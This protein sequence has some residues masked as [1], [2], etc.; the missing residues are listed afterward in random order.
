MANI[1][2]SNHCGDRASAFTLIELLV[3]IAIIA[4]LAAMLLPALSAAKERGKRANCISNLHQMGLA[5]HVYAGDNNDSVLPG[6]RDNGEWYVLSLST[7]TYR[8]ISNMF[9]DKVFDC[10]NLYPVHYPGITDTPTSRHESATGWYIGYMY[11]GGKPIPT[12]AGWTSPQ[13][14]T[15]G[16]QMVLFAEANTWNSTIATIAHTKSGALQSP[17]NTGITPT[18]GRDARELGAAGGHTLTLDG[19]V[20]W[21]RAADWSTN[22]LVFQR[23]NHWAFW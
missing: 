21:R 18:G 3:V 19:A 1:K 9:G 15:D 23:G 7:P 4:I 2:G 10:P 5:S 11:L 22:Y 6:L 14:L 8:Y 17:G 16:P 20:T 12:N 13:H